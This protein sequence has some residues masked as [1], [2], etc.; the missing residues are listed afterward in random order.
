M[1]VRVEVR[2]GVGLLLLDR[3]EKA[4]AYDRAHL[5]ALRAGL[6]ELQP[7]VRVLVVASTGDRAFCAGADLGALQAADPLDALDLLSQRVFTEL[8]QAPLLTI[9]AVQGPAVAGGCE[10]ALAA[11]LRVVGPRASF[12]LP[13]TSLGIIPSAGG[14]TRLTHLLGPSI[15]KQ[16]ILAGRRIDADLALAWGLAVERHDDPL[17]GALALAGALGRRDPLAQRLAKQIIDRAEDPT[18]LDA[19][20]VAEA[21][22]YSR[23]SAADG[24]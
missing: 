6:Q 15:A 8:H 19:E 17:A 7:Q 18:S 10:L 21:L 12:S 14:C 1:S 11:D 4:H 23:R 2:E 3:P 16:V 24:D 22:L 13:E 9:A 5:L 20:R